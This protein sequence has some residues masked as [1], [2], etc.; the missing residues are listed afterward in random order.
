MAGCSSVALKLPVQQACCQND[1]VV[2]VEAQ[3]SSRQVSALLPRQVC[4]LL[5]LALAVRFVNTLI[6]ARSQVTSGHGSISQLSPAPG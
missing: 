2:A 5:A 6:A 4:A 3:P 1:E